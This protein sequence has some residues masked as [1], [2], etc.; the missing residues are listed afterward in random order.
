M[1]NYIFK[2]CVFGDYNTGKTSFLNYLQEMDYVKTY[3]PTIGVEYSTK[4]FNLEDDKKAKVTF[5]DCAGQERF[6]SI[7]ENFFRKVTGGMLFFDVSN[8]ESYNSVFNW[9]KKFRN[10]N[11]NEIPLILVGN[12]IDKER[13]VS[14]NDAIVLANNFNLKYIETSV[15]TKENVLNALHLLIDS[16][17]DQKDNNPNIKNCDDET[18]NE[19]QLLIDKPR[20][21]YCTN[22]CIF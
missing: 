7:T 8:R 13:V 20:V 19:K 16:I 14:T 9:I 10:L 11:E 2:I 17:Y 15:K 18:L 6:M 5:W 12:K 21:T 4:I 22:C 3:E 1:Y